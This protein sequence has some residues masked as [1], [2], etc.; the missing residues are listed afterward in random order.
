MR[1]RF[2]L[3]RLL[4]A[5][6]L[7]LLFILA[8]LANRAALSA[9]IAIAVLMTLYCSW[10]VLSHR[11]ISELAAEGKGSVRELRRRRWRLVLWLLAILLIA[12]LITHW[13]SST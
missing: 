8:V 9:R 5:S 1:L 4:V 11:S 7:S 2:T 3:P 13:R 12:N 10:M 6:G